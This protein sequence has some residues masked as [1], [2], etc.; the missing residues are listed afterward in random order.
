MTF[1]QEETVLIEATLE[2]TEWNITMAAAILGIDRSTL[3]VKISRY[4]I[5]RP[6]RSGPGG[7]D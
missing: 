5:A 6:P 2:L 1:E 3:Y 7:G 4:G